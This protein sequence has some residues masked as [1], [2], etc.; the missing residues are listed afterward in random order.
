MLLIFFNLFI[1]TST[2]ISENT[3]VVLE[4]QK[5]IN[6]YEGVISCTKGVLSN[7]LEIALRNEYF[8]TGVYIRCD[9]IDD[10]VKDRQNIDRKLLN[11]TYIYSKKGNKEDLLSSNIPGSVEE[12]NTANQ[13]IALNKLQFQISVVKSYLLLENFKPTDDDY[14][15]FI[16]LTS[17]YPFDQ[18][19]V[20]S[21]NSFIENMLNFITM[22]ERSTLCIPEK[23]IV[24]S[25]YQNKVKLKINFDSADKSYFYLDIFGYSKESKRYFRNPTS[26][27]YI[28]KAADG[29]LMMVFIDKKPEKRDMSVIER[30][31]KFVQSNKYHL[32]FLIFTPCILILIGIRIW[33]YNS[34]KMQFYYT[35]L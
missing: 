19:D 17:L 31:Q 29:Q 8:L 11:H 7:F 35:E 34:R 15:K 24:E 18:N 22:M 20:N 26:L 21:M 32:I 28:E 3:T 1:S 4:K 13:M 23:A 12:I 10:I 30:F 6:C 14:K 25:I 33:L 2:L 9:L 27:F 5:A 16:S